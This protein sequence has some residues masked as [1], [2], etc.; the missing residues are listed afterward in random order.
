MP[1]R[2]LPPAVG[3]LLRQSLLH[4]SRWSN[5]NG[6]LFISKTV[7]AEDAADGADS[8][9]MQELLLAVAPVENPRLL[10]VLALEYGRLQPSRPSA[11][12]EPEPQTWT[13][14]ESLGQSLLPLLADYATEDISLTEKPSAEKNETNMRRFFLSR[15]LSLLPAETDKIET[16]SRRIMPDLLGLS[17]RKGLQRLNFY[18]LNVRIHGSGKIIAQHPA[19]GT[20]LDKVETC[21]LILAPAPVK[22]LR[23]TP[24]VRLR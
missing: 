16:S 23:P 5:E 3:V 2:I 24:K 13:Q 18:K 14:L 11:P 17:L 12:G 1:Q 7:F 9:H 19:A 10:L 21:K 15:Q 8:H 20:L 6:F 22:Q 4:H